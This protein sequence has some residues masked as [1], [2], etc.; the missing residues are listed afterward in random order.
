MQIQKYESRVD[1]APQGK[2]KESMENTEGGSIC[3]T[4]NQDNPR[5]IGSTHHVRPSK[6]FLET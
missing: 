6:L 1:G 3:I 5:S 4:S 2:L